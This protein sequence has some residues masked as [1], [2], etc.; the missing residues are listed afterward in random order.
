MKRAI[1]IVLLII[2]LVALGVTV[3]FTL[4]GQPVGPG[5]GPD[6]PP[7]SGDDIDDKY[8]PANTIE[9][10]DSKTISGTQRREVDVVMPAF[11]NLTDYSFQENMNKKIANT[12]NPYINE[13]AIVA[14]ETV[15]ATKI[16][17]YTV[18]YERYNNGKYLSLLVSQNYDTG[19][20]GLRSNAWKD[21]YTIDV[22]NNQEMMLADVC[23]SSNYKKEIVKE[24]NQ[25]AKEKDIQLFGGE[26]LTDIPDT[27]RF[28][29]KEQKLYI[30]FEPASVAPY[31]DGEMHFEMPYEMVDGKFII[32]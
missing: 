15:P 19:I 7:E 14:D 11:S 18:T 17:R 22:I 24:I 27:Q 2:I 20:D 23:S 12:I 31:L 25:Q 16:Y 32:N 8:Y 9:V 29:I 13:I 21:T 28:Y 30:Y 10:R 5:P 6:V 3:Y 1:C 26:G 4:K